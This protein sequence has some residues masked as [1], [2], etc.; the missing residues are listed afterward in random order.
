MKYQRIVLYT[1]ITLIVTACSATPPKSAFKG[2]P[3]VEIRGTTAEEIQ[4]RFSVN[5][6]DG[7]KIVQSTPY[8]LTCAKQMGMSGGELMYRALF[9]E[10]NASNPDVML[11][12]AWAKTP[13][14]TMRIT[15]T[16]WVEHQN[17]FGRVTR[18][19]FND[20]N[21]KHQIQEAL[22]R[23]KRNVEESKSSNAPSVR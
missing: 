13:T 14:G 6:L 3:F 17:A 22:D 16:V 7:G 15:G 1:A 18:E 21:T 11:Q 9:T 2:Q 19:D 12:F 10:K 8:S 5:C 4:S 23:L 20:D